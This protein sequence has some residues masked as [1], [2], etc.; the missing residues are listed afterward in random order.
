MAW[1]RCT[2]NPEGLYVFESALGIEFF[3]DDSCGRQC[4]AYC[5]HKSWYGLFRKLEKVDGYPP[6]EEDEK[7]TKC[8]ELE[9][10]EITYDFTK[11]R[12]VT[13]LTTKE[14][15]ELSQKHVIR[16]QVALTISPNPKT[17]SKKPVTI[18]MY[19]VTWQWMARNVLSDLKLDREERK[20]KQIK[21][22]G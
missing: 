5:T 4:I 11:H 20:S 19:P 9:V 21:K 17:K 13:N 16:G 8:G 12:R 6:W 7:P 22:K 10:C 18:Y 14:S 2:S 15:F 1:I 3:W